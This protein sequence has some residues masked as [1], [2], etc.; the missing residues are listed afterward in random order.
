MGNLIL[1]ISKTLLDAL[2]GKTLFSRKEAAPGIQ[3]LGNLFGGPT[4]RKGHQESQSKAI[5]PWGGRKG[6]AGDTEGI[7]MGLES[8]GLLPWS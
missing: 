6:W 7:N 5:L 1:R 8:I 2:G 4:L 3:S